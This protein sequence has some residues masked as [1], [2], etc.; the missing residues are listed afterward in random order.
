MLPDGP[1][2]KPASESPAVTPKAVVIEEAEEKVAQKEN[3]EVAKV[4]K[5]AKPKKVVSRDRLKGMRKPELIEVAQEYGVFLE[6]NES[7][8]DMIDAIMGAQQKED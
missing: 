5:P 7:K 2:S 4:A 1:T 6:G 3:K 8:P